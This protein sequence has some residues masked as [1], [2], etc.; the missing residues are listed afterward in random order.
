M[1]TGNVTQVARCRRHYSR[2]MG[3]AANGGLLS[4]MTTARMPR[5]QAHPQSNGEELDDV[6]RQDQS[7]DVCPH[8]WDVYNQAERVVVCSHSFQLRQPKGLKSRPAN[9]GANDEPS[10]D[11][12]GARTISL[13]GAEASLIGPRR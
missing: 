5:Q 10:L 1:C 11:P 2:R 7:C 13:G 8:L 3:C 6:N 9:M 12:E 4:T